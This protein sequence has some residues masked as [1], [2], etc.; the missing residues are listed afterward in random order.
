MAINTKTDS[1]KYFWDVEKA[2]LLC[3]AGGTVKWYSQML[4]KRVW[5]FIKMLKIDSPCDLVIP[6]LG[7]Y[8]REI[9][10]CDHRLICTQMSIVALFIMVEMWK[11]PKCPSASE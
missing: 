3:T 7:I 2:K 11:Q 1:N 5:Q 4:W 8:P 10:I 6:I 9:K